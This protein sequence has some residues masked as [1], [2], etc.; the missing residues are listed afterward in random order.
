MPPD[1]ILVAG[2]SGG[3]GR[4]VCRVLGR[5]D[6][7][8]RG[9]TRSPARA[10]RIEG[11]VD[12]VIVADLLDP[13]DADRAV[14]G[15]DAVI[16]TVGSTPWAVVRGRVVG[17]S[18]VDGRG[19]VNL[20]DAATAAGVETVVMESSL[21]V[22]GDRASWMARAF[23]VLIRPVVVAKTAAEETIRESGLR[24]TIVRPGVLTNGE[25]T[26]DVPV[27]AAGAGLWGVVSRADVAELLVAAIDTE[28][29]ANRTVEVA[30]HPFQADGVGL[31][32]DWAWA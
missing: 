16:T 9:T 19:N 32:I 15:V 6:A 25:V 1:R 28:D 13:A 31:D 18:F 29:A 23:S 14:A 22:G 11:L 5:T 2:A 4:W 10:S 27:A 21:G 12:E 7:W 20:V 26:R 30:T 24:Y 8:I 17:G 3:T